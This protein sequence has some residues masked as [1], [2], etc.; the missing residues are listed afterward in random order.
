MLPTH[1]FAPL[2]HGIVHTL[3]PHGDA[4]TA[5]VIAVVK[6]PQRDCVFAAACQGQVQRI[7]LMRTV[8]NTVVWED[9]VPRAAIDAHVRAFDATGRVL[10][11]K[12]GAGT[13]VDNLRAANL[14]NHRRRVVD[15][16]RLAEP[17]T[18]Q[19]MA[20]GI[21]RRV[22]SDNSENITAV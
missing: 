17:L 11:I 1:P 18:S 20:R 14:A 13:F 22:G 12:N 4:D 3:P 19:G 9:L 7:P 8:G 21:I 5:D 10:N 2:S 15:V 6:G 16:H